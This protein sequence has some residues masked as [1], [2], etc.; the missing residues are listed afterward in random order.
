MRKNAWL[1]MCGVLMSGASAL[2]QYPSMSPYGLPQYPTQPMPP[3]ATPPMP[4]SMPAW[5]TPPGAPYGPMPTQPNMAMPSMPMVAPPDPR[6]PPGQRPTTMPTYQGSGPQT[7]ATEPYF[8]LPDSVPPGRG[9][10]TP[11]STPAEPFARFVH[12]IIDPT[13]SE[14]YTTYEGHRYRAEERLDNSRYWAQANYIH[15]WV[16]RDNTPPLLTGSTGD[17]FAPGAGVLGQPSTVTLLGGGSIAPNEYSGI[18]ASLGM[19]LDPEKLEAVE[20]AGFWL[21]KNSR[22]YRFASDATGAPFTAQPLL[23]P[24][25]VALSV[26]LPSVNTA[27]FNVSSIMNFGGA[28]VNCIRNIIR[29]NGWSLDSLVGVRYLYLNDRLDM[30]QNLTVLPGGA[31]FFNGVAQ[32]GGSNFLINDS[33]NLTNRF[34]GGQ[35]GARLDWACGGFDLG[36]VVKVG[37]GATSHVAVIDGSTTLNSTTT[38]PGGSLAQ[39]SNIGRF[40]STDFSVVPELNFTVGYQVTCNIRVLAGYTAIDWNRIQRASSQIDRRVDLTQAPSSATFAPGVVGA[41]PAFP[42]V[43]TDFWAQGI[44]VGIEIKY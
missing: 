23:T 9:P 5:P 8:V 6:L 1:V 18:Q 24:N 21:G 14:P 13:P 37:F 10:M 32:G 41:V 38:L 30:N 15:W 40:T 17:P 31:I 12:G 27:T 4:P 26:A 43:R 42:A 39:P 36:A 33:F 3:Y 44:N 7:D 16:R 35:I 25:E 19:W 20:V 22:Q 28:E 34:Y 11:P 2:A 29:V